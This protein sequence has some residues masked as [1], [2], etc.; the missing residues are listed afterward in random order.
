MKEEIIIQKVKDKDIWKIIQGK[1]QGNSIDW[2]VN[3]YPLTDLMNRIARKYA[4]GHKEI[5]IQFIE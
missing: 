4:D 5:R 1:A 3:S 2:I